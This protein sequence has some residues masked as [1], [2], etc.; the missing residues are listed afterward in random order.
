MS[1]SK[2]GGRAPR[3]ILFVHNVADLYGASRSLLRLVSRLPRDRFT[4]FVLLPVSG[5]LQRALEEAGATVELLPD[6]VILHRALF[7]TWGERRRL[8][9]SVPRS[10]VALR[11]RIRALG[12]DLVHTNSAAV[13]TSGLAARAAG[14]PHL[15]HVREWFQEF[16]RL[17]PLYSRYLLGTSSFVVAVSGPVAAQFPRSS[18]VV[19]V[20]N[21]F[22]LR[23]FELP[24]AEAARAF[25]ERFGLGDAFVVGCVGRIKLVRKGQEVLVEAVHG[26]KGRGRR[27]RCVIVGAPFPGNEQHL[28]ALRR[29]VAERGLEDDVVFAGEIADVRPAY[30]AMDVLVLP[31]AEPEPFGGVVMEAMAMGVPVIATAIGGSVEQVA[32][33]ETGFLVPPGD[34]GALAD[35]IERLIDTPE[36]RQRLAAAGPRRIEE[37]FSLDEMVNRMTALYDAA[38]GGRG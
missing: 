27:T 18:K 34:A 3:R 20:H 28:S 37:R 16:T 35:R 15:Y 23:E 9:A 30:A 32:E 24:R 13:V 11:G 5:P 25:R 38:L 26:L 29:L 19:V 8:L 6:L 4:P 36:L 17:W 33:G 14:V 10:V 21:G 31:S 2:V 22:D 1:P 12:A 7:R